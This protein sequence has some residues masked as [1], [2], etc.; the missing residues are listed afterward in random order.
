[1]INHYLMLFLSVIV[2]AIP[3]DF[4]YTLYVPDQYMDNH[5]PPDGFIFNEE[6]LLAHLQ[7]SIVPFPNNKICQRRGNI[8]IVNRFSAFIKVDHIDPNTF[9]SLEDM[10]DDTKHRT[11]PIV[12]Y[13]TENVDV[14]DNTYH[15]Y[16][17]TRVYKY[18]S[19]IN[20][21]NC[22]I[23][24][25]FTGSIELDQLVGITKE[26]NVLY[27]FHA[28]CSEGNN[29]LTLDVNS[30]EPSTHNPHC[31]E[32]KGDRTDFWDNPCEKEANAIRLSKVINATYISGAT[33][34][35]LLIS[36]SVGA[37]SFLSICLW[38]ACAYSKKRRQKKK[39]NGGMYEPL[40]PDETK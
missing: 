25:I 9:E 2:S 1:M 32:S 30:I 28:F 18:N 10:I 7:T 19:S 39:E 17:D 4:V 26:G 38:G 11:C 21:S 31:F 36:S 3:V 20:V 5:L 27:N 16:Q 22:S 24:W 37:T 34:W 40:S 12:P 15:S 13:Y 35:L 33:N 8:S 6:G 14:M 29:E 23:D